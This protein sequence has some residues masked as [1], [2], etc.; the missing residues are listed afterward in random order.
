MDTRWSQTLLRSHRSMGS[1]WHAWLS[2]WWHRYSFRSG[3]AD[4]GRMFC[5]SSA[6]T[7]HS[8]RTR[9]AGRLNSGVRPHTNMIVN[10]RYRFPL[11]KAFWI[12][13][14]VTYLIAIALF[15]LTNFITDHLGRHS[16]EIINGQEVSS[17]SADWFRYARYHHVAIQVIAILHACLCTFVVLRYRRN[18]STQWFGAL[19]VAVAFIYLGYTLYGTYGLFY[20]DPNSWRITH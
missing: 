16:I 4:L 7:I 6:L 1:R 14:P 11:W 2:G 5:W 8:S 12:V 13:C 20:P 18:T 17:T 19:C 10:P 9:F 3:C 15:V